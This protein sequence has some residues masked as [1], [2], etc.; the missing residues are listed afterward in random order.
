MN[1]KWENILQNMTHSKLIK[2]LFNQ[3]VKWIIQIAKWAKGVIIHKTNTTNE[4]INV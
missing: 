3:K 4:Q 2:E 1:D